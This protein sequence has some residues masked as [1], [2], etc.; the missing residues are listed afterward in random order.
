M[1]SSFL[2]IFAFGLGFIVF[3]PLYRYFW[4]LVWQNAEDCL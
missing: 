2:A 3:F 4:R 1:M